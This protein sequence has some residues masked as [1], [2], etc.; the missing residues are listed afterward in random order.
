[1]PEFRDGTGDGKSKWAD[2]VEADGEEGEEGDEQR[3][4][5][6]SETEVDKHGIKQVTIFKI[7]DHNRKVKCVQTVKVD[8][9]PVRLHKAVLERRTWAKF[10]RCEGHPAGYHGPNWTFSGE[11]VTTLDIS[12]QHLDLKPKSKQLEDSNKAAEKAFQNQQQGSFV[13]WRPSQRPTEQAIPLVDGPEENASRTT[14]SGGG[15]REWAEKHGVVGAVKPSGGGSSL[16]ALAAG[17]GTSGRYVP[18]SMRNAD[19]SRMDR[20]NFQ[21]RDDTTTVR[22]SNLSDDVTDQDLR[23][24]FRRF[25]A[26]QRVYLAKDRETGLSRGFAFI[27]FYQRED[28][29]AAIDKLDGHGYDHLILSVAWAAPSGDRK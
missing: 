8:K 3:M 6:R 28:A 5:E 25:G 9:I 29:Q 12:E 22:V 11:S 14:Y 18:P 2:D 20:A 1:M 24:L 19:G 23:E 4:L 15:A 10:G 16:E 17:A 21:E 7:N 27:N 13:A 26:I